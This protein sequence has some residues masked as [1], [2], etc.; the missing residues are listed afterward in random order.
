MSGRL[1]ASI[2]V[3][4]MIL[5]GTVTGQDLSQYRSFHLKSNVAAVSAVMGV[6]KVAPTTLHQ[7]PALLQSLEWEPSRWVGGT[8]AISNDPVERVDFSFYNDQL[9]RIAVSYRRDGTKGLTNADII[10]AVSETYGAPAT[11]MSVPGRIPSALEKDSGT[12]LGRWGSVTQRLGLYRGESYVGIPGDVVLIL[13][14][15]AMER[16]ADKAAAEALRREELD[17]PRQAIAKEKADKEADRVEE[18]K[19]RTLNKSVFQP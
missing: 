7:Q 12:L 15:V 19:I 11:P 6:D 9:F 1:F 2:V 17:A 16:L 3:G 18:E 5:P 8:V 4:V 13:T 10:E 14:D